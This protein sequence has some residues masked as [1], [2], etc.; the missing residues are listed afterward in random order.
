MTGYTA[1][2]FYPTNVAMAGLPTGTNLVAVEVHLS[3]VTN[4]TL[5]FD[6]ELIGSGYLLPTPSLS[7]AQT[8]NYILLSW[9]VTSSGSFTLY[10]TTNLAAAESWTMAMATAQTNGGQIVVTQ[11]LNTSATFFRLQGP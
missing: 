4:R 7:I 8:T 1:H 6:M 2:V 3:S 10:S 9:P 11:S 5:G